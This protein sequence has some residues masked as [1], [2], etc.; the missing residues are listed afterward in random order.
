MTDRRG[1]GLGRGSVG[2]GQ[3]PSG[4][5]SLNDEDSLSVSRLGG[6][7]GLDLES[8]SFAPMMYVVRAALPIFQA[9]VLSGLYALLPFAPIAARYNLQG[10]LLISVALFTVFWSYLWHLA[11]WIEDNLIEVLHPDG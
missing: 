7:L 8:L 1:P 5:A 9:L 6:G 3:T 10:L 2:A 4:S 11:K